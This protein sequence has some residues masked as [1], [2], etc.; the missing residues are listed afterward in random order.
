MTDNE[1]VLIAILDQ[2]PHF[3]ISL[4]ETLKPGCINFALRSRV[5]NLQRLL[6]P[7]RYFIYSFTKKETEGNA[8]YQLCPAVSYPIAGVDTVYG[9]IYKND[10]KEPAKTAPGAVPASQVKFKEQKGADIPRIEKNSPR[11]EKTAIP[12]K[13]DGE[14][15]VIL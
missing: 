12:L 15:A 14:Q 11:I 1:L 8:W 7:Y 13:W 5:S 10:K 9:L 2:R 4:M 6:K 3:G